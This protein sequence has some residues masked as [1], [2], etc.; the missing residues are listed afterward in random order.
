MNEDRTARVRKPRQASVKIREIAEALRCARLELSVGPGLE[1]HAHL[2]PVQ[3][4]EMLRVGVDECPIMEHP[5]D[6]MTVVEVR[7][8][9]EIMC[10]EALR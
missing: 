10:Q 8:V 9:W 2:A 3:A 6:E 7:A 5:N 1:V 4:E